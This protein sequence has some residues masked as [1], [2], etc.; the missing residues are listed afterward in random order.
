MRKAIPALCLCVALALTFAGCQSKSKTA[1]KAPSMPYAA[2]ASASATPS[3]SPAATQEAAQVSPTPTINT[4][5]HPDYADTVDVDSL[6]PLSLKE[7]TSAVPTRPES[8]G[9]QML[10]QSTKTIDGTILSVDDYRAQWLLAFE[11]NPDRIVTMVNFTQTELYTC[12]AEYPDISDVCMNDLGAHWIEHNGATW[13]LMQLKHGEKT[14]EAIDSGSLAGGLLPRVTSPEYHMLVLYNPADGSLRA[15]DSTTGGW[16]SRQVEVHSAQISPPEA[17]GDIVSWVEETSRG[18][19]IETLD[20]STGEQKGF[21]ME[22]MRRPVKASFDGK[23]LFVLSYSG[24]LYCFDMHLNKMVFIGT[25]ITTYQHIPGGDA[26]V[27]TDVGYEEQLVRFQY[28]SGGKG[29]D[30]A[31]IPLM[32]AKDGGHV[33]RTFHHSYELDVL[34]FLIERSGAFEQT[35]VSMKR[36][37][38]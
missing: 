28:D 38:S 22:G 24:A 15:L 16:Y 3:P 34:S 18:W 20:F 35:L 26:V 1:T 31:L 5:W 32:A 29:A 27:A 33:V 14:P 12:S 37:G 2:Q 30:Y 21:L 9:W 36:L 23:T 19:A 4:D 10:G 11:G 25:G 13:R 6:M 7:Y 8:A 17:V